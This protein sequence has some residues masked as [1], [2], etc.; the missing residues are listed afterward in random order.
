MKLFILAATFI[1]SFILTPRLVR[2]ASRL[3]ISYSREDGR[4]SS[5]GAPL[6]GGLSICISFLVTTG[7]AF[8]LSRGEMLGEYDYHYLGIV[9]GGSLV[10]GLGI[11]NDTRGASLPLKLVI[12]LIAAI[13]LIGCGYRITTITCFFCDAI[14]IG[15]WGA[16]ILIAWLLAVT[17]ALTLI[18]RID[19]LACGVAAICGI[20]IFFASLGGPPFVP[21]IA[22]ALTAGCAGFL[23][24]NFYPA[25]IFLGSTGTYFLGFVLAAIAVQG[26]FKVTAAI[27]LTLPLLALGIAA[28]SSVRVAS[29][30]ESIVRRNQ[31]LH[32][33]LLNLGYSPKQTVLILYLLQANL[34]VIALVMVEAGRVLALAVFFLVG[35]MIY[36]LFTIMKDYRER[37]TSNRGDSKINLNH[38]GH[39]VHEEE[40]KA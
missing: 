37:L 10:A 4:V 31:Q 8:L 19:G 21:I 40:K 7:L 36:I 2:L 15:W 35:S 18:D 33:S 14:Q 17:N 11:Y 27:S 26:S 1:I 13:I 20:T 12:Q 39:E 22:L 34:G 29:G 16:P 25:R 3:S 9:L 24:Y 5:R 23:R 38:E 30:K 6:L 32:N 28:F